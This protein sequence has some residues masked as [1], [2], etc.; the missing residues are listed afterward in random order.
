[1]QVLGPLQRRC[2][3]SIDIAVVV[4]LASRIEDLLHNEPYE[5]F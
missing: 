3:L 5:L 4:E 2:G 1:M